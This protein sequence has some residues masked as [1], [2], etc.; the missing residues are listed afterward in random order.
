MNE[1]LNECEP[2]PVAIQ[3][4]PQALPQAQDP[5]PSSKPVSAPTQTTADL[6]TSVQ[7]T[8]L[9]GRL[10][11]RSVN[12]GLV[13]SSHISLEWRGGAVF[14]CLGRLWFPPVSEPLA[15]QMC[16]QGGQLFLSGGEGCLVSK[17]NWLS[18]LE[19]NI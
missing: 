5:E 10:A 2:P 4:L 17:S 3:N 14:G 19:R 1:R 13:A 6:M 8:P 12:K 18:D 11:S 15:K 9:A 7:W 16:G